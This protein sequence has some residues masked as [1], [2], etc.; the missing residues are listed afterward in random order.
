MKSCIYI[1]WHLY[2]KEIL[3]LYEI[4]HVYNVSIFKGNLTLIWNLAC[5][6]CVLTYGISNLKL[7]LP[8]P[9]F[10]LIVICLKNMDIFDFF[11][12]KSRWYINLYFV[13]FRK[14]TS[15]WV[16]FIPLF[17]LIKPKNK[18]DGQRF[19]L[20]SQRYRSIS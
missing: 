20:K 12:P 17:W 2:S 1:M 6:K 4:L 14:I 9:F 8:I 15:K 5:I 10:F 7:S 18:D 19:Q 13:V 16:L 11:V 3:H